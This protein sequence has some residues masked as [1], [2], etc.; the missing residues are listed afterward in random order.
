MFINSI[1]SAGEHLA[2]FSLFSST[3]ICCRAVIYLVSLAQR[4]ENS[5]ENPGRNI[6][7]RHLRVTDAVT[8]AAEQ[9]GRPAYYYLLLRHVLK[10]ITQK[11]TF[12]RS[13]SQRLF[14]PLIQDNLLRQRKRTFFS[15]NDLVLCSGYAVFDVA[16]LPPI[17]YRVLLQGKL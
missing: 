5:R 15:C 12:Y 9:Q 11:V 14:R 4:K 17:H 2:C 6:L 13:P 16:A 7:E 1:A 8:D 10:Q 3:I